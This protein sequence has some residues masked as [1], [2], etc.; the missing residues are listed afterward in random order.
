MRVAI[1]SFAMAVVLLTVS[2]A[3][4]QQIVDQWRYTLQ[5]PADGWQADGF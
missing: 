5:R 1:N 4:A 2:S 3:A